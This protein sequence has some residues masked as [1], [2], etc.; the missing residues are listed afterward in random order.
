MRTTTLFALALSVLAI[1]VSGCSMP[2]AK[3]VLDVSDAV[4]EQLDGTLQDEPEW[5]KFTCSV[6]DLGDKAS[7]VFMTKVKKEDAPVFAARHRAQGDC[8]QDAEVAP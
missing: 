5:V 6:I 2:D 4:C 3:T 1:S 7:H 8:S